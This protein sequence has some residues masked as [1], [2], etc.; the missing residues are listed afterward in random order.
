MASML[1]AA[2]I[3]LGGCSSAA[4]SHER[5]VIPSA[6][7]PNPIPTAAA[8]GEPSPSPSR[9]PD[10]TELDRY[11]AELAGVPY[12]F[13][14]GPAG[15]LNV[16]RIGSTE[17]LTLDRIDRFVGFFEEHVVTATP[18]RDALELNVLDFP[19]GRPASPPILVPSASDAALVMAGSEVVVWSGVDGDGVDHGVRAVSL[20]DGRV[21]DL[22][23]T[24]RVSAGPNPARVITI[25]ESGSELATTIC[26]SGIDFV[27]DCLDTVVID[28]ATGRVRR[29]LHLGGRQVTTFTVDWALVDDPGRDVLIESKGKQSWSTVPFGLGFTVWGRRV[30][31]DS[32]LIADIGSLSSGVHTFV[33]VDTRNGG[34]TTLFHAAYGGNRNFWPQFSTDRAL[35]FGYD[36]SP[37]DSYL[38]GDLDA[39]TL[40]V[41]T[42]TITEHAIHISLVP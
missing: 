27:G 41:A 16:G 8:T 17:R 18:T 30:T 19:S 39:A 42:G 3:L 14:R 25:S 40:D 35:A 31:A 2:F 29:T 4:P 10:A 13:R 33:I 22:L 6:T 32:H 15:P 23:A 11:P 37:A 36:A 20:V 5:L 12:V 34:Q 9:M 1:T 38:S 24:A 21:R 7:V 28:V 26:A